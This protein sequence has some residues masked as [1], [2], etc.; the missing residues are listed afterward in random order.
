MSALRYEARLH[1]LIDYIYAHIDQS[2]DLI[3]MADV[4]G[5]SQYHLHRVYTGIYGESLAS[6]VKRLRLH[7]AAGQLAHSQ[8]SISQVANLS[9]YSHLQS[10]TRAFSS[11]FGLAPAT[12]RRTGSHTNFKAAKHR[13]TAKEQNMHQVRLETSSAVTLLAYPHTGAY[14]NI[15]KAFEKLSGWAG[16]RGL[17]NQETRMM[18]VYFDDPENVPEAELRCLAGITIATD[19][20][21][22]LDQPLQIYELPEVECAVLRFQGPYADMAVA[23]R[24]FYGQWLPGSGREPQDLPPFEVYLNDPKSVAPTELLTDIYIPI[25]ARESLNLV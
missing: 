5:I 16:I 6:M 11:E 25:K 13:A 20:V 1:K 24:W 9:G 3:T 4:A 7:Y 17:F 22:A 12:Y 19:A 2:L 21:P 23:Y 15:G 18:G 14:M 10:F 8:V